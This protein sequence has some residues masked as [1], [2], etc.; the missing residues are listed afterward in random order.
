MHWHSAKPDHVCGP[1]KDPIRR[2]SPTNVVW[3]VEEAK[4]VGANIH[5]KNAMRFAWAGLVDSGLWAAGIFHEQGNPGESAG[6]T[7]NFDY[8]LEKIKLNK[9]K[10]FYGKNKFKKKIQKIFLKK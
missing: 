10:I 6:Y 3:T 8:I 7:V 2:E 9:N 5:S 4:A 1:T